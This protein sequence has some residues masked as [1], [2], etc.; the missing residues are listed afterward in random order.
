[1]ALTRVEETIK[2]MVASRQEDIHRLYAK[3]IRRN[4]EMGRLQ[5]GVQALEELLYAIWKTNRKNA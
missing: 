3:G 1:M 4:Y 2:R 5:G